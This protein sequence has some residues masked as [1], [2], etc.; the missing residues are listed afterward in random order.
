MFSTQVSKKEEAGRYVGRTDNDLEVAV[1][2][3]KNVHREVCFDLLEVKDEHFT[4]LQPL[5]GS[6]C[7][8]LVSHSASSLGAQLTAREYR[9]RKFDGNVVEAA[10]P[11]VEVFSE[12][13]N[14][15]AECSR[16]VALTQ[17]LPGQLRGF[18]ERQRRSYG[19]LGE[20]VY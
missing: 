9:R 17:E 1:A 12:I 11:S 10:K 13:G 6:L 7:G 20:N 19:P 15:L 8:R 2:A 4:V 16:R 3:C 5:Q 14:H 18:R